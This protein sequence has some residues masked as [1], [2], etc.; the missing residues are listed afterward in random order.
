MTHREFRPL[1]ASLSYW[2]SDTW[3]YLLVPLGTLCSCNSKVS[4]DL[5]PRESEDQRWQL[6]VIGVPHHG[7]SAVK[8]ALCVWQ[9]IC[10]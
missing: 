5:S 7:V 4:V 3:H 2:G 1:E 6:S 10:G 9:G 8:T